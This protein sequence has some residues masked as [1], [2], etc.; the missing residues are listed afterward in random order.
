MSPASPVLFSAVPPPLAEFD[1]PHFSNKTNPTMK[2]IPAILSFTVLTL[3]SCHS[4]KKES[5]PMCSKETPA[6]STKTAA[7]AV[8]AT[9]EK[10]EAKK[11]S[12]IGGAV[13]AAKKA[14]GAD[15]A[16]KTAGALKSGDLKGAAMNAAAAT[17]AGQAASTATSATKKAGEAG[18]TVPAPAGKKE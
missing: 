3:A 16:L 4:T 10:T 18:L 2:R 11:K 12:L 8:T 9:G 7:G 17:P 15:S 5:C 1:V 6:A 14:S 13:G